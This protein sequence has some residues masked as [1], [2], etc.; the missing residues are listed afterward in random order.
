MKRLL[1]QQKIPFEWHLRT[2]QIVAHESGVTEVV[3]P[4]AGSYYVEAK[5]KEIEDEAMAYILKIDELGGATKAIDLGYIQQEIMD[6]SY[7]YQKKMEN[8]DIIVV[9]L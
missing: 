1:F 2:Q 4:L 8:G 3:D 9:G 5:T 7:D 6:A